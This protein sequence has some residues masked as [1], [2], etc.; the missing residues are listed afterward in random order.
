MKKD[1]PDVYV[2]DPYVINVRNCYN[3]IKERTQ[4]V[5]TSVERKEVALQIIE[6]EF[7]FFC[8]QI[9]IQQN[10]P[11]REDSKQYEINTNHETFYKWLAFYLTLQKPAIIQ[12]M[13]TAYSV[14]KI[15]PVFNF[16]NKIEFRVPLFMEFMIFDHET[17]DYAVQYWINQN[18][19]A[20]DI[21]AKKSISEIFIDESVKPKIRI[22]PEVQNYL[23]LKLTEYLDSNEQKTLLL[24]VL[25]GLFLKG[26]EK[27]FLNLKANLFCDLIKQL[28]DDNRLLITSSKK[29]IN[30]WICNN[31]LFDKKGIPGLITP[32]YCS[33]LLSGREEPSIGRR[34]EIKDLTVK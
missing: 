28:H 24:G 4:Q 22:A 14:G 33:Q 16:N 13:L 23:K 15:G 25:E 3:D 34:F 8:S 27:V 7:E 5:I 31:F 21:F 12:S 29:Q 2:K 1:S 26:N 11:Y 30:E 20:N 9:S 19:Y 32:S 17:Q 10:L 18:N 6:L